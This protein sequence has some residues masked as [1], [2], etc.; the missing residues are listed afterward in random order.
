MGYNLIPL[1]KPRVIPPLDDSF[2]PAVLWNH[3][4]L[5]GIRNSKKSIPLSIVIEKENGFASIYKT[6]I[7]SNESKF[8]SF[9]YF[10]VEQLIK[11][12]LWIYGG[13]KIIIGGSSMEP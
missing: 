12:I 9:N 3:T 5:N 10:Y 11:T 7:F 13:H 2:R 1:I 4:F 8:T 6:Q